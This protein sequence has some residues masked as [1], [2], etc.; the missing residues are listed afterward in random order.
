MIAS[1]DFKAYS[2]LDAKM[3]NLEAAVL[4]TAAVAVTSPF[5]NEKF[6]EQG[7]TYIAQNLTDFDVQFIET[8]PD[9]AFFA[10]WAQNTCGIDL[11]SLSTKIKDFGDSTASPMDWHDDSCLLKILWTASKGDKLDPAVNLENLVDSLIHALESSQSDMTRQENEGATLNKA[12]KPTPLSILTGVVLLDILDGQGRAPAGWS[13]RIG[14]P[15]AKR[16]EAM[17]QQAT[18]KDLRAVAEIVNALSLCHKTQSSTTSTDPFENQDL[19]AMVSTPRPLKDAIET[20][21]GFLAKNQQ[22]GMFGF[23]GYPDPG[24]TA[25][26]LTAVMGASQKLDQEQPEYVDNG[27]A[28]LMSLQKENGGIFQHGLANYVTSASIM[29]FQR[30]NDPK[31]EELIEKA[32]AFLVR[33][34]ADEDEGYS[35]EE[36]PHYGGMGYGGDERPDLSNTQMSIEALRASGLDEN[37]EAFEKAVAF[38]QKCQNLSEFNPTR[39]RLSP[40]DTLISGN[41][42]GGFYAPGASK[43]DFREISDGIF[44]ARSYGSMTYALLKSYLLSG[45]EPNDRRV[46]AAVDWI[47]AHY[48]LEENPGFEQKKGRETGQQGLYYYFLTMARALDLLKVERVE[49]PDGASHDW[50]RELKEKLLSLQREDGS[51]INQRAPRWF[52]GNPVLATSY[53]LLVL[54]LCAE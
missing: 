4:T 18:A 33:L 32:A 2:D 21:L 6:L 43:A 29:A 37:H 9:K 36:D 1:I 47:Q 13:D 22:E 19:P 45:L 54:D 26:A 49:T 27:L 31:Y 8:H 15:L 7:R 23:S 40:T 30:A 46:R 41:D 44:V 42:G 24:I 34:Q 48:T 52:E 5:R 10:I 50:R 16:L 38:L 14:P 17:L 3:N 39:V 25:M 51:W 11:S 12:I 53:A 20:G 35:L 28:Y